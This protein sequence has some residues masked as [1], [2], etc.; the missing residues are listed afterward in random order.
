MSRI[1]LVYT[2]T[3]YPRF[4]SRLNNL[5]RPR[6]SSRNYSRKT[7]ETKNRDHGID[8]FNVQGFNIATKLILILL[9]RLK[10]ITVWNQRFSVNFSLLLQSLCITLLRRRFRSELE[11]KI[12]PSLVLTYIKLMLNIGFTSDFLQ[13]GIQKDHVFMDLVSGHVEVKSQWCGFETE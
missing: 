12:Y 1:C 13:H 5:N 11:S 9:P 6:K 3:N 2:K 10:A 4:N 8:P 7:L